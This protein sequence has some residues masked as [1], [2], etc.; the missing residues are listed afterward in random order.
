MELAT[1]ECESE[2]DIQERKGSYVF[3]SPCQL[4]LSFVVRVSFSDD[5]A[6]DD[7]T[8]YWMPGWL[9]RDYFRFA[10]R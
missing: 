6:V 9:P 8:L 7:N 2:L 3:K 4:N 10:H 1:G 5:H